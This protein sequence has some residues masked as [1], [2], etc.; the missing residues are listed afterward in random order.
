MM[1]R[2]DAN[3]G[4]VAALGDRVETTRSGIDWDGLKGTIGG[5]GDPDMCIALV[6]LDNPLPDGRTIVGWP[7]VCLTPI[8]TIESLKKVQKRSFL[9][10]FEAVREDMNYDEDGYTIWNGGDRPVDGDLVIAVKVR[11]KISRSPIEA[12][13]WPQITWRHREADDPMNKWDIVA[14]KVVG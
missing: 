12:K 9:D 10:A 8:V 13:Q 14:Y 2:Y 3:S 5:W 4:A 7:I 6:A 1:F 11:R